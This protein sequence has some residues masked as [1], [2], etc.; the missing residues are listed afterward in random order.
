MINGTVI[1]RQ[2]IGKVINYYSDGADDY[3]SKEG[4]A[5]SW[6]G[7]GADELGLTSK[8]GVD[9]HD[10][11]KML[12]GE[13]D[14]KTRLKR[15]LPTDRAKER[16]GLDLTF[17]AP[18]SVSLQALVHGD[19]SVVEAHDQAVK[20]TLLEVERLAAARQTTKGKV[21]IE[22]T[23]NM[24]AATFRHETSREQEPQLHTHAVVMNMT[25]RADGKWRSMMND[26]VVQ[27]LEH[28]GT[29]YNAELAKSLENQGFQLRYDKQGN[30]DLAHFTPQQLDAFSSRK[31]QID[32]A[33]SEK[34]LDRESATA[35]QRNE[36]S[37]KT[38]KYK[39]NIDREELHKE[40]TGR[41]KD[42][43]INFES[44][45]WAGPGAEKGFS[46]TMP[47]TFTHSTE[48]HAD[49]AVKFAVRSLSER[50]T[51]NSE[52]T[53][54]GAALRHGVGQLD[55]N[56]IKSALGR[57]IE[58]GSVMRSTPVYRAASVRGP[59]G[60]PLAMTQPAWVEH[61]MA[62]GKDKETAERI[63]RKAISSQRIV[64][65][66]VFYTTPAAVSREKNILKFEK[67][68]RKVMPPIA[69]TRAITKH[70]EGGSHSAEQ[71]AAIFKILQTKNQFSAVHG[72][73]GVGK[74]YMTKAAQEII[75]NQG[76]KVA[77]LAPYGAQVKA[78]QAEGL[79]ARTLAAFLKAKDK[80]IDSNTVVFIDEAGVIPARQME[81]L[82]S[83][84]HKVGARAVF[85]GD[86]SQTKA[87]E[88]GKPFE[89]LIKAGMDVSY[90]SEIQRQKSNPELLK[91]VQL[92]AEGK[93]GE[94]LDQMKQ[95]VK[96]IVEAPDRHRAIAK[97]F[98]VM[99]VEERDKSIIVT[100]TNES[101]KEINKFVREE[102][103]LEGRGEVL[104][105]LNRLDTT[106]AERAHSRYY[107]RGSIVIP[108]IDS[109]SLGLTRGQQYTVEDT[110]PGN[111]LTISDAS[112]KTYSF[113][114]SRAKLSVYSVED[115]ELA[116]GD[117][118]K[119]TLNN[120][121]LD[122]ANGDRFTVQKLDPVTGTIELQNS[123]GRTITMPTTE[124][125]FLSLAYASTVHSAQGMTC[126]NALLNLDS[127]SKTTVKEVYYV[128]LSRA[129]TETTIYTDSHANLP[130]AIQRETVKTA[131]LDLNEKPD[132][133]DRFKTMFRTR[134]QD[135][136]RGKGKDHSHQKEATND[137]KG[138]G[139]GK[140][141]SQQKEG[142]SLG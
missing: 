48:H 11:G 36:A 14:D 53:I 72:F 115:T 128:G 66:T 49:E 122:V 43:G 22:K 29:I 38:R 109:K 142:A 101:R 45:E 64:V 19:K 2:S 140:D 61:V 62:Q 105:L 104:P 102:L 46:K 75:E 137:P 131:A 20:A 27:N 111:L 138:K 126:E 47:R 42:L 117:K 3:Y 124:K 110:G 39:K 113:N 17:S 69:S 5:M 103:G 25:K 55:H 129:K 70:L 120:K 85:L 132:W 95:S 125:L 18:K 4:E 94:S 83:E 59:D 81:Q 1:K 60:K 40:W 91:A 56:D 68:G 35:E 112:G 57:A 28:F 127:K 76:M 96:E 90:V 134:D 9:K 141:H 65:D 123:Q 34:G 130:E 15:A 6:V 139:K 44:R 136:E 41:A 84:I 21:S 133:F 77:A 52:K 121:T 80:K 26:F 31:A 100:G 30:F 87:I 106:Q 119:V 116:V 98:A 32:N 12:D 50:Q 33:L 107:E 13:I 71:R 114:P 10:F 99:G 63:I 108:E 78:L 86:T 93:T 79:Q 8:E 51:N 73:A 118:V 92:A 54:V 88:A 16:I 7:K 24:V 67:E 97:D 23:G 58:S 89:Q 37:L 135:H 74:S 82:M